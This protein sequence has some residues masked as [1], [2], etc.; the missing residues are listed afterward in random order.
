MLRQVLASCLRIDAFDLS[1]YGAF[2]KQVRKTSFNYSTL[3]K[4]TSRNAVVN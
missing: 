2:I 1:N 4:N 3:P